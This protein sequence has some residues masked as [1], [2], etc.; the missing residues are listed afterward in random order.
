MKP[1]THYETI[2]VLAAS[3]SEELWPV[4]LRLGIA[5]TDEP[6]GDMLALAIMKR[7]R[8]LSD[9]ALVDVQKMVDRELGRRN[10]RSRCTCH[11][12]PALFDDI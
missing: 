1:P 10:R 11:N 7:G 4:A 6:V 2:A 12:E 3:E 8:E 9:A 5:Y